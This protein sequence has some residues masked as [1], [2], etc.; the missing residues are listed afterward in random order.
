MRKAEAGRICD[1]VRGHIDCVSQEE[2]YE[3]CEIVMGT[4]AKEAIR[5]GYG[6]DLVRE[7]PEFF[8]SYEERR[9]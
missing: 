4:V 7:Y 2:W 3:F 1:F 6:A 9:A 8:H 5:G